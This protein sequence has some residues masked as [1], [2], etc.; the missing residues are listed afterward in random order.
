MGNESVKQKYDNWVTRVC[1][2][3]GAGGNVR[4]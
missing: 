2:F 1:A 3:L 4:G